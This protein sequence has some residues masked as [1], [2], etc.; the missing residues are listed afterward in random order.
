MS[1]GCTV[2][3]QQ[4]CMDQALQVDEGGWRGAQRMEV[5]WDSRLL[6]AALDDPEDSARRGDG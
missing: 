4:V 2:L 3:D 6:R 5:T 1:L